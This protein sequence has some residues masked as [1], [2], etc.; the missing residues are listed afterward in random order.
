MRLRY[1]GKPRGSCGNG[2]FVHLILAFSIQKLASALTQLV[3]DGGEELVANGEAAYLVVFVGG[4]E[5]S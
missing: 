1:Q 2:H 3:P 4:V 5:V